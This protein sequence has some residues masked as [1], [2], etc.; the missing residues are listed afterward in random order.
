MVHV[1]FSAWHAWVLFYLELLYEKCQ[2]HNSQ[3]NKQ[4]HK[5]EQQY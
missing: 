3:E 2:Y 5:I 1:I 4:K